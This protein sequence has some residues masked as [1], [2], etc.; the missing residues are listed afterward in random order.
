[1]RN[2]EAVIAKFGVPP[3]SVPDY[4]ALVGDS[5]DGFPGVPRWGAKSTSAVLGRYRHLEHIPEHAGAWDVAVRGAKRLAES[6]RAHRANAFLFRDLATLREEAV[7]FENVDE[8]EWRGPTGR[9]E[10]VAA[11]LGR[12]ELW[13]RAER[14]H[15]HASRA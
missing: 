13:K 9:F 6:L 1:V 12:P 5:A 10:A 2:E 8:L 3:R 15:R 11:H 14:I 7:Q 4:L